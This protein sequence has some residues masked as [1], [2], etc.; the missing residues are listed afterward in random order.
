MKKMKFKKRMNL[1]YQ[2]A[3]MWWFWVIGKPITAIITLTVS[4]KVI[5]KVTPTV[6]EYYKTVQEYYNLIKNFFTF[7]FEFLFDYYLKFE[8]HFYYLLKIIELLAYLLPL[9][10]CVAFL[11]LVER[12]VMGAIQRHKVR[13]KLDFLVYYSL[14]QMD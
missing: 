2:V 14:L 1:Y 8:L 9:L 6:Q 3:K 13:T 11:T 10:V 4:Y 7:N 12:K 5:K